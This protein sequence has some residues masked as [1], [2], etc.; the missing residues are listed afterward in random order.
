MPTKVILV[1]FILADLATLKFW[2]MLA[3]QRRRYKRKEFVFTEKAVNS[4]NFNNYVTWQIVICG[5]PV[6]P[7]HVPRPPLSL[8]KAK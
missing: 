2:Q 7:V 3:C 5:V 1:L 4:L 8:A 6:L